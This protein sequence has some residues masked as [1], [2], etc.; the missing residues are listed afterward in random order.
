MIKISDALNDIVNGNA[1]LEMGLAEKI[2]NLTQLAQFLKPIVEAKTKKEIQVP[3]LV[4]S[5]S[6]LQKNRYQYK[7]DPQKNFRIKNIDMYSDL[8]T[9]TLYKTHDVRDL[10]NEIFP[11]IRTKKGFF[12]LS[13]SAQEVTII[14]PAEFLALVL[15]KIPKATVKFQKSPLTGLRIRFDEKSYETPGMVQFI[16]QKIYLQGI[17]VVELSSTYTELVLYFESKDIKLA[18]ETLHDGFFR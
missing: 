3:A 14:F 16:L 10:I 1:F 4:M 15:E 12:E 17:N 2:F 7:P 6:R 18:F 13:E 5:L 8:S 11:I 9:V